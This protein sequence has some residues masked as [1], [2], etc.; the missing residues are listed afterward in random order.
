LSLM[1]WIWAVLAAVFLVGEIFTAGFFLFPFSVG[2]GVAAVL[3]LIGAPSWL[4][5]VSFVVVSGVMVLLSR[6]LAE[7]VSKKP[8]EAVGVDR[9][10]GETGV[11]IERIDPLTDTGRIRVKKD[12]WR[13]TSAD[14]SRIEKDATVRVVKVEGT[15]LVV[16]EAGE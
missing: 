1:F 10:I 9:L 11:V 6:R 16:E 2:A 8:P 4:Q 3:T 14:G 12:Q 13:V 7:K 15:H 5:W